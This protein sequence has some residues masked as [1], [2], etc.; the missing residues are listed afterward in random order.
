MVSTDGDGVGNIKEIMLDVTSGRVAYAVLSSGGFLGIGDK[1]L[2]IPWS[3]LTLDTDNK[4]F[5]VAASSEQIRNSPG[6]DKD[7]WPSM[8]GR[9]W[10]T[11]VHQHYGREP[12]WSSG[13]TAADHSAAGEIP[14]EA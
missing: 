4:C 9:T 13:D 3:A 10:A 11:T 8:A 12:Y 14:G 1:L 7:S 2:A 6:F 5:R